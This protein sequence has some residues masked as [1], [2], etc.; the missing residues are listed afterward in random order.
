MSTKGQ[1]RTRAI[2]FDHLVG[3]LKKRLLSVQVSER[4]Y[5]VLDRAL[6]SRLQAPSAAAHAPQLA[7]P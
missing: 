4:S 2:L 5:A 1:N 6:D 3:A 7:T